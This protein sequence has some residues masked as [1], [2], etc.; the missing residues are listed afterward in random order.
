[1]KRK[2]IEI[3]C[4]IV[5]IFNYFVFFLKYVRVHTRIYHDLDSATNKIT[6][7]P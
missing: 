5:Y 2:L 4:S 6:L 3:V 1:M 7:L